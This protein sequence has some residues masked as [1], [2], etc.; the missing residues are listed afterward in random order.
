MSMAVAGA[1]VGVGD[2][3]GVDTGSTAQA[4]QATG[5]DALVDDPAAF[6]TEVGK[7]VQAHAVQVGVSTGMQVITGEMKWK[8]AITQG[9][10]N[11]AANAAGELAA[12]QLCKIYDSGRGPLG[13]VGHKVGHFLVGGA[14]GAVINRRDA[15]NGFITG[16]GAAMSAEMIAELMPSSMSMQRRSDVVRLTAGAGTFLLGGDVNVA[17]MTASNAFENNHAMS[18]ARA[19]TLI[20]GSAA[21]GAWTLAGLAAEAASFFVAGGIVF[22]VGGIGYLTQESATNE[23]VRRALISDVDT[24]YYQI[25]ALEES[26]KRPTSRGYTPASPLAA[27]GPRPIILP[28]PFAERLSP[29]F[30]TPIPEARPAINITPLPNVPTRQGGFTQ[31]K[32]SSVQHVTPVADNMPGT[33]V[34]AN[35]RHAQKTSAVQSASNDA[36]ATAAADRV[37]AWEL[38]HN[39]KAVQN[40][41]DRELVQSLADRAERKIGSGKG[42]LV[43]QQKHK[44]AEET[45]KRYQKMTGER[46]HI[47]VEA[48]FKNG[49]EWREG[50]GLKDS[51]KAD[52]HIKTTKETPDF[53]FGDAKVT[54]AQVKRYQQQLPRKAD[55]SA[56]EVI[57]VKPNIKSSKNGK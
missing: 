3:L 55:K 4:S 8:E 49:V 33:T 46:A 13:Y 20:G 51:V 56:A 9:V 32:G 37:A 52:L 57:E 48:R 38:K 42:P 7:N 1:T 2:F 27:Y 41:T 15:W 26:A 50:M 10:I 5:L 30:A 47:A 54:P 34:L 12:N 45:M 36:F 53:K 35:T 22:T 21:A 24:D 40:M 18:Q 19:A 25:L 43:G 11:V 14:M 31:W 23:A 17:A 16:G 44:Y 6:F 39:K 29:I 28:T